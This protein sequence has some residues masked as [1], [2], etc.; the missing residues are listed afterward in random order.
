MTNE[1]N[2]LKKEKRNKR[3]KL[4]EEGIDPYPHNYKKQNN[5]S[6]LFEKYKDIQ[7]GK[8]SSS[9]HTLA[10]RIMRKRGMGKAAFFNIQDGE[11]EFQ[12]Y[13]KQEDFD[14]DP[15]NPWGVWKLAD[16]GDIVGVSG[17]VFRTQ[18]GELSLRVQ[19]LKMLC[20]TL[21]ILPEKYHG[22]EDKELRYRFRHLDLIMNTQSKQVFKTRSKIIFEI[23]N[24]MNGK[25]FMEVETPVLQPVYGGAVAVP[26]KTYYRRL[27]SDMYLKISPEI[28]LKKLIVGG[29]EK[30]Y[31]IGK[32]F[33]N[34]G[35]DRT[36]NPE[37]T[38]MEYY[39][40]YTDYE[41][42]MSQFEDLVCH[43][44]QKIKGT[45]KFEYLNK[46][47]N[48]AKPWKRVSVKDAIKEYGNLDVD[49]MSFAE[50]LKKLES[51]SDQE[52]FSKFKKASSQDE[53]D[54]KDELIML[55]FEI[56]A[57]KHFWNPVFIKDFPLAVSPLTKKHR[58]G[59]TDK[60]YQRLV[61]RFEPIIAGMELGNAYT[62]LNDPEDQKARLQ[63]QE[64][65]MTKEA[66]SPIDKNFIH[67]LEVG[68]PPTG[69]VGLGVE[70]L[71][72]ILTNQSNIR[73]S[74]LFP[75]LKNK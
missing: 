68:M 2:I 16:I 73:D 19:D 28:Y 55:A 12:C 30:V 42:Q 57:E 65:Y 37:F 59:K 22:L 31:E 10:G 50:L 35:I 5:S 21:E 71:V 20:K 72:M 36:H 6:E 58:K 34:E 39:E 23:R 14:S 8:P 47:I 56:T 51:L 3:E 44:V 70:R 54:L 66:T 63:N 13:I 11:G 41:D 69:G 53:N 74:M 33:R 32:N 48:F 46:E 24:Y 61:E 60:S 29:F 64:R 15:A 9:L 18:K 25:G 7:K 45:L 40:A 1:D 75:I 52:D 43:I 62:E 17:Q 67:S 27:D 49:Q 26:F 38:M 4:L